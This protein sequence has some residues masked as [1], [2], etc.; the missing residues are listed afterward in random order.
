[1]PRQGLLDCYDIDSLFSRMITTDNASSLAYGSIY[2]NFG[3]QEMSVEAVMTESE[4]YGDGK[5]LDQFSRLK[6]VNFSCKNAWV[7]HAWLQAVLAGQSKTSGSSPNEKLETAF[8]SVNL[9]F[10][11]LDFQ[12]KYTGPVGALAGDAHMIVHKGKLT[13]W[14]LGQKS[15]S[16]QE[17]SFEGKG[18][19]LINQESGWNFPRCFTLVE[20]ETASTLTAGAPD[21][22]APTISSFTPTAAA[23]SVPVGN[24]LTWTFS[25]AL[26]PTTVNEEHFILATAAGVYVTFSSVTLNAA[27]TIVTAVPTSNLSAATGY[28]WTVTRGVRDKAGNRLASVQTNTFTTA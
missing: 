20:N 5:V 4:S 14:S 2:Q 8:G 16:R 21:T 12:C 15:E 7:T 13:K 25:E 26:D 17:V 23:S 11:E 10:F 22:T 27:G 24:P 6:M 28:K 19:C 1:M 18:I 9:P 3:I